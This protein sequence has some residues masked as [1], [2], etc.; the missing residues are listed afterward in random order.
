ME[1]LTGGFGFPYHIKINP[2]NATIQNIIELDYV[3]TGAPFVTNVNNILNSYVIPA[4]YSGTTESPI[5]TKDLKLDLE[6]LNKIASERQIT[7]ITKSLIRNRLYRPS[8]I[9]NYARSARESKYPEL[10]KGLIG[11]WLPVLGCTGKV[12]R[13]V[14]GHGMDGPIIGTQ[15][16]VKSKHG[17]ALYSPGNTRGVETRKLSFNA[18]HPW[19][20]YFW[21]AW[22]DPGSSY[23]IPFAWCDNE[24]NNYPGFDTWG[25]PGADR[26]YGEQLNL[27]LGASSFV[28]YFQG[29]T[30]SASDRFYSGVTNLFTFT[31]NGKRAYYYQNGRYTVESGAD[32]DIA[33]STTKFTLFNNDYN[34]TSYGG[35]INTFAGHFYGALLYDCYQPADIITRLSK[36][37]T[38]PFHL[39][40][41]KIFYSTTIG[42][43]SSINSTAEDWSL[44]TAGPIGNPLAKRF[45]LDV[46]LLSQILKNNSMDLN[47][48]SPTSKSI[49]VN[50]ESLVN[51]IKDSILDP[52][53]KLTIKSSVTDACE[54]LLNLNRNNIEDLQWL[55]PLSKL[56]SLSIED[57]LKLYQSHTQ[58]VENKLITIDAIPTPIDWS[59]VS[60]G[61]QVTQNLKSNLDYLLTITSNEIQ[62]VDY[63]G[64]TLIPL[65]QR[66][67][68]DLDWLLS[69]RKTLSKS[70]EWLNIA[71]KNVNITTEDKQDIAPL[72]QKTSVENITG[73]TSNK[74]EDIDWSATQVFIQLYQRFV[75]SQDWTSILLGIKS[76]DTN[77]FQ[78]LL[79]NE[80]I[81]ADWVSKTQK[82]L[83][84][85]IEDLLQVNKTTGSSIESLIGLNKPSVLD[86]DWTT[87][88]TFVPIAQRYTIVLDYLAEIKK[89]NQGG[90]EATS[91][92][93]SS[94]T[95]NPNWVSIIQDS[96]ANPI[97][98]IFGVNSNRTLDLEELLTVGS[99]RKLDSDYLSVLN[100]NVSVD[101]DYIQKLLDTIGTNFDWLA[102][103]YIVKS[104]KVSID[105]LK[106]I[107]GNAVKFDI[108][109]LTKILDNLQVD[110]DYDGINVFLQVSPNCWILQARNKLWILQNDG[111]KWIMDP[112]P[113]TFNIAK[114][115]NWILPARNKTWTLN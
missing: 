101:T 62:D 104:S 12:L 102:N 19:T 65:A 1:I 8:L 26:T 6:Y 7:T 21:F 16:W 72:P 61:I 18:N 58:S 67:N 5:I 40:P 75:L 44:D 10:W 23:W 52:E 79:N 20:I 95:I 89:S 97:D 77:Y 83:S 45:Y 69:I 24:G 25:T 111:K 14:S 51:I 112:A 3:S 63:S 90:L 9:N 31:Y 30:W 113:K 4:D 32:Y 54:Y 68:I 36:D 94:K 22:A 105:Y 13:D 33:A 29:Q 37:L 91:P 109:F 39:K 59:I 73:I 107:L 28:H 84:E 49:S 93:T 64:T 76:I 98:F 85:S 99:Q 80:G 66:Y 70:V 78:Q 114:D 96:V 11:A 92:T 103:G 53:S 88:Q 2:I 71:N 106:D 43:S 110:V 17:P 42:T 41:K 82:N 86:I 50:I 74:V 56:A 57:L 115:L 87:L 48:I 38:A 81:D 108:D 46:D 55:T 27:S 34:S 15:R 100:K 60:A 35:D 47:F